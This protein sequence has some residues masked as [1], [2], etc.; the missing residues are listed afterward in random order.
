MRKRHQAFDLRPDG[1]DSIF[2]GKWKTPDIRN[3][4]KHARSRKRFSKKLN[5]SANGLMKYIGLNPAHRPS[6]I[7]EYEMPTA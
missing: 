3:H 2:Y 6:V 1:F 5:K 4:S 7:Y